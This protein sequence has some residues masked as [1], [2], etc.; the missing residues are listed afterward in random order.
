MK[1]DLDKKYTYDEVI[2]AL[3]NGEI[4]V[5]VP[6]LTGMNGSKYLLQP[7]PHNASELDKWGF[8]EFTIHSEKFNVPS[9][10]TPNDGTWFQGGPLLRGL[11][12]A[13][14]ESEVQG[15]FRNLSVYARRY[16]PFNKGYKRLFVHESAL[17]QLGLTLDRELIYSQRLEKLIEL[18]GAP[19]YVNYEQRFG[20][21][22]YNMGFSTDF[23]KIFGTHYAVPDFEIIY[24][25]FKDAEVYCNAKG[26]GMTPV[27]SDGD[28]VALKEVQLK[29]IV[30][31]EIYAIAMNDDSGII[32]VIR[33][34]SDSFKLRL[35]AIN[36][37]YNDIEIDTR[38]ILKIYKVMGCIKHF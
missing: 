12:L 6:V 13:E 28:V 30:Y 24:K 36:V 14:T 10:E 4:R 33:R 9:L 22:Y 23:N 15:F 7:S 29:D 2:E 20:I 5:P 8:T 31:G 17:P 34:G 25:P 11:H 19:Q 32:R 3:K 18:D 35:S 26:D 27:I 38:G 16:S 37:Y 1:K 21:P